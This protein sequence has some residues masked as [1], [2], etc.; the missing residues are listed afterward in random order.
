[1]TLKRRGIDIEETKTGG[2]IYFIPR[3]IW[4]YLSVATAL[5]SWKPTP[6]WTFTAFM[7][8]I[9]SRRLGKELK[10]IQNDGCPVGGCE[11]AETESRSN[12][13]KASL[14]CELMISKSGYSQ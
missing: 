3:V 5:K 2:L 4:L 11:F 13:M 14:C 1:V 12:S 6:E 7:S 10:E 8:S 9:S